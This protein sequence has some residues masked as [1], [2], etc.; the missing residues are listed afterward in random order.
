MCRASVRRR[1]EKRCSRSG[2]RNFSWLVSFGIRTWVVGWRIAVRRTASRLFSRQAHFHDSLNSAFCQRLLLN[3]RRLRVGMLCG[4]YRLYLVAR[5]AG[6]RMV[7]C[8][9][10]Y[11]YSHCPW[12]LGTCK[13]PF[14][15]RMPSSLESST[16]D[17]SRRWDALQIHKSLLT[18]N[19]VNSRRFKS[20]ETRVIGTRKWQGAGSK[21]EGLESESIISSSQKE[22]RKERLPLITLS[23]NGLL[24]S[25]VETLL[26]IWICDEI[27][28]FNVL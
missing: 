23:S 3:R 4:D 19:I 5:E 13:I 26:L 16:R 2:W 10:L 9:R 14:V 28:V 12:R 21:F 27:V 11:S 15:G 7:K 24:S 6:G 17:N 20:V 25:F 18:I 8:T 1:G 22:S